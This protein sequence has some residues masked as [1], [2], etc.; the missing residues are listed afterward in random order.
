MPCVQR[1]VINETGAGEARRTHLI[2]VLCTRVLYGLNTNK[3]VSYLRN[4]ES[5]C[6]T[7]LGHGYVACVCTVSSTRFAD[8]FALSVFGNSTAYR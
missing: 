6:A 5:F 8:A 4:W 1:T 3:S 7:C 2:F